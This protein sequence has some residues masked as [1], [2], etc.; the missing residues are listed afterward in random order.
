MFKRT[1][2]EILP[3]LNP[4]PA[5]KMERSSS[6]NEVLLDQLSRLMLGM[7]ERIKEEL[8]K[9][10]NVAVTSVHDEI[11]ASMNKFQ[12]D[13]SMEMNNLHKGLSVTTDRT[14]ENTK[15]IQELTVRVQILEE[16]NKQLQWKQIDTENRDKRSNLV[17]QGI[18]ESVSDELLEKHF[19]SICQ[20]HL[21]IE[22]QILLERIHQVGVQG[23]QRCHNVVVKFH[24]F[25]DR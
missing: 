20:E 9:A 24:S 19:L 2:A 8:L 10:Q 18:P 5:K 6:K 17:I 15:Q 4:A 25:K 3:V 16:E 11:R 7:E 12:T 23:W 21:K 22:E 14:D 1:S 13:I